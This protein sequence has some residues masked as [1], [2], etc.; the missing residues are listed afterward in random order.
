MMF[1]QILSA[2]ILFSCFGGVCLQAQDNSTSYVVHN[3]WDS[4]TEEIEELPFIIGD[5]LIQALNIS[6]IAILV[7]AL[8]V[9]SLSNE[10]SASFGGLIGLNEKGLKTFSSANKVIDWEKHRPKLTDE[11]IITEKKD[12]SFPIQEGSLYFSYDSE[13]Y[14]RVAFFFERFPDSLP[15]GYLNCNVHHR[16]A[17]YKSPHHLLPQ[18]VLPTTLKNGIVQ[19]NGY[20][21]AYQYEKTDEGFTESIINNNFQNYEQ[22]NVYNNKRQLVSTYEKTSPFRTYIEEHFYEYNEQGWVER[23]VSLYHDRGMIVRNTFRYFYN[24]QGKLIESLKSSEYGFPPEAFKPHES[25][26]A[27]YYYNS[28]GLLEN[29]VISKNKTTYHSTKKVRFAFTYI[30]NPSSEAILKMP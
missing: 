6:S 11:S 10:K 27:A 7:K 30:Y 1:T 17:I 23:M 5:S 28:K 18:K 16:T 21:I 22:K 12:T 2:F 4:A 24:K 26:H 19:E 14:R 20:N 8:S 15:A 25:V 3:Y 13:N 29:K 9:D